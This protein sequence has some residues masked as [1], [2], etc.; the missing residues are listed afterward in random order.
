MQKME[1]PEL[2]EALKNCLI[3]MQK[4]EKFNLKIKTDLG[5]L[6]LCRFEESED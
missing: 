3:M 1:C 4:E 2:Q 6:T 5:Y